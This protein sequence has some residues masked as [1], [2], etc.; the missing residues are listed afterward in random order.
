MNGLEKE[1]Y[2]ELKKNTKLVMINKIVK[3]LDEKDVNFNIIRIEINKKLNYIKNNIKKWIKPGKEDEIYKFL[4]S[5]F[6]INK[7]IYGTSISFD[8]NIYTGSEGTIYNEEYKLF[9]P[10]IYNEN[11]GIFKK[12]NAD[13][14]DY[15]SGS[16]EWWDISAETQKSHMSKPFKGSI[17]NFDI[18]VHSFPIIV[19]DRFYGLFSY[20]FEFQKLNK[21]CSYI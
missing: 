5:I 4:Y 11:N 2:D 18:I 1:Y 12:Y 21:I 17:S 7:Y 19:E 20:F 9:A 14:Y 10:I 13:L 8:R 3:N 15:T 16:S 6:D